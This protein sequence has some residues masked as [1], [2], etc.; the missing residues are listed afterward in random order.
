V[1][2]KPG[3]NV[4]S[5]SADRQH[6]GRSQQSS[7]SAVSKKFRES[8]RIGDLQRLAGH[9]GLP[10]HSNCF[11][12]ARMLRIIRSAGLEQRAG[13]RM[14]GPKSCAGNS[15][16]QVFFPK[17]TETWR[18]RLVSITILRWSTL[19]K[20][21]ASRENPDHWQ[22]GVYKG[23]PRTASWLCGS[24]GLQLVSGWGIFGRAKLLLSRREDHAFY[25][26][27]LGGSVAL[28]GDFQ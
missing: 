21:L 24:T 15:V 12:L 7:I 28:P 19:H 4:T 6:P 14:T 17:E 20:I 23:D 8:L 25:G 22:Y 10:F 27:R 1:L 26:V 11:V 5:G 18:G 13:P 2:T 9:E 3:T 16:F